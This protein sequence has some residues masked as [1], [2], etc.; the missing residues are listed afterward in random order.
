M[1]KSSW[2]VLSLNIMIYHTITK[3]LVQTF[4]AYFENAILQT[5]QF[6]IFCV[7][8]RTNTPH[9]SLKLTAG[10]IFGHNF[11]RFAY[12]LPNISLTSVKWESKSHAKM[13]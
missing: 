9:Q 2:A 12:I 11:E 6:E 5:L 8:S 7:S 3:A 4:C 1:K 13:H 10:I